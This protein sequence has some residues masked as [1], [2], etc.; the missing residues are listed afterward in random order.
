MA[1][2]QPTKLKDLKA[3]TYSLDAVA[4]LPPSL[5][6]AKTSKTPSPK[7][8]PSPKKKKT[9]S[10]SSVISNNNLDTLVAGIGDLN[11]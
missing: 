5:L 4:K 6:P 3:S 11:I 7:V 8:G 10:P 2:A 1:A 9:G